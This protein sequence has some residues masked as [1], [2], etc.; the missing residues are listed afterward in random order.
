MSTEHTFETLL[1]EKLEDV[2]SQILT[3]HQRALQKVRS[4]S[5]CDSSTKF[6]RPRSSQCQSKVAMDVA[7]LDCSTD[8]RVS[9]CILSDYSV[10][11][12]DLDTRAALSILPGQP[13]IPTHVEQGASTFYEVESDTIRD[14]ED[15]DGSVHGRIVP[16]AT[17]TSV[18][19]PSRMSGHS[20]HKGS[21]EDNHSMLSSNIDQEHDDNNSEN[22]LIAPDTH[23]VLDQWEQAYARLTELPGIWAKRAR[24]R[25]RKKMTGSF[26]C[27]S[28]SN[29]SD[30]PEMS[31]LDSRMEARMV[32]PSSKKR[33]F[34]EAVCFLCICYDIVMIPLQL[35]GPA[36]NHFV[37]A[38][39]WL[40]RIFW[41][42]DIPFSFFSGF[43]S[44][45]GATEIRF[46]I[47]AWRYIRLK[48]S[49]DLLLVT[50]DWTEWAISVARHSN[51][52][53]ASMLGLISM[54]RA[55]RPLRLLRLTKA[56]NIFDSAHENIRSEGTKIIAW[57]F[58]V[59]LALVAL[60]HVTA[61][62]WYAIR[63][64][65]WDACS[66]THQMPGTLGERYLESFHFVLALFVGEHVIMPDYPWER[67][68]TVTVLFCAFVVTTT[69][70]GTLTTA[71][72][73]LQ[74]IASQKSAQ[75]A[76]LNRYLSDCMISSELAV[77]VQ[78]NARHALRER[79]RNTPECDVELLALISDPLRAE[80]HYEVL[81][82]LLVRHPFFSLYNKVNASGLRHICHTSISE[83]TFSR[84]DVLF[85]EF[86]VPV[87]PRMFFGMSGRLDYT[88][89]IS[90]Q[91]TVSREWVAEAVLWTT[92]QHHGCL[93]ACSDC[94]LLAIDA[95]RFVN[96]MTTFHSLHAC[97]YAKNF[98]K[99]L[100]QDSR[101]G[102][103]SD[104]GANNEEMRMCAYDAFSAAD[105][106]IQIPKE[107]IKTRRS[108]KSSIASMPE[109]L[110]LH[111]SS[112]RSVL[113]F[114]VS[115]CS[116]FR[117]IRSSLLNLCRRRTT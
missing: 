48:L 45:E 96:I 4:Q 60:I 97:T 53:G 78:R 23:K 82:P 33:L 88:Q 89:G 64:E 92:W 14:Q 69:F 6:G 8:S 32:P 77:R 37:L 54:L 113:G 7:P 112:T 63:N 74:I 99:Q 30:V 85:L 68:F 51:C 31:D 86:E 25:L 49:F 61:C 67:L 41:T 38:A 42:L 17:H 100:N 110:Q 105:E 3:E 22:Q 35:L 56:Q 11:A 34:W 43:I 20:S 65:S 16:N 87:Q 57:V 114:T 104:I 95:C 102:S 103:L 66:F 58:V 44:A 80:I 115:Q 71:M 24:A 109:S 108:R 59:L 79:K 18:M 36:S 93:K 111:R 15:K 13:S 76:A 62:I 72:T 5:R 70:V 27:E 19:S 117:R 90:K 2:Y 29:Y 106:N 81:S 26:S 1:K 98:V 107:W 10:S 73:R 21:Q 91:T 50:S 83:V 12:Q 116:F 39:S 84:G 9:D 52:D 101:A 94:R 47:V 40:I 55:L 28:E 75:F 46:S